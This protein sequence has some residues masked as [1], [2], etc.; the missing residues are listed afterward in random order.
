MT[1][2]FRGV[3][4]RQWRDLMPSTDPASVEARLRGYTRVDCR[5]RPSTDLASV[6]ARLRGLVNAGDSILQQ[7]EVIVA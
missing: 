5:L 4:I 7:A 2:F 3:S 6:E 1:A